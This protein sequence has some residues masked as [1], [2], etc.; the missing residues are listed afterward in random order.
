MKTAAPFLACIAA[1]ALLSTAAGAATFQWAIPLGVG[2]YCYQTLADGYGGCAI[3]SIDGGG[4]RVLWY[5]KK[6][7]QRYAKSGIAGGLPVILSCEKNQLVFCYPFGGTYQIV[8]VDKKGAVD[9]ITAAN[10][11]YLSY[12]GVVGSVKPQRLSDRKGFFV[13]RYDIPTNFITLE[14]YSHK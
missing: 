11:H 7:G 10:V 1:A 6:G 9:T 12:I 2:A 4:Y 3:V 13:E 5:D 8:T 14:R